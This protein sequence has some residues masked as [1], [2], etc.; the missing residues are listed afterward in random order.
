MPTFQELY[1]TRDATGA[2]A[3]IHWTLWSTEHQCPECSNSFL[4]WDSFDRV[5]GRM[6]AFI[7]CPACNHTLKRSRLPAVRS[8][9]A[10]IAY[11]TSD[12]RR[13]EKAPD[14]A[15]VAKATKSRRSQVAHWFPDVAIDPD[16][17]MY[18]RCALHLRGIT[19]VADFYTDRN[20][21]ALALLWAAITKV[22]DVRVRRALMFAFTNTAW[23][24]TRMRRFN[25]RGGQRPLTGTLYIPQLSSEAN[26]LEVMRNKVKQL[27][28]YFGV[29]SP[30][31]AYEPS[32]LLGSATDLHGIPDDC[33]DYVFTDPP[34]GSN[35]Y[36]ADCNLIWESWLGRLTD[37]TKEAVINRARNA[38][39]GGRSLGEYG[40]LM[41]AA[42]AECFRVLKPGAW[43]TVVF[44]NTNAAVW[45]VIRDSA[46][47]AG[48]LIG[49]A[50]ALDRKQQSHKG[51]KGR[52][53]GE[54][55]AHFDVVFNLQKA[56]GAPKPRGSREREV[57]L[58]ALVIEALS[59]PGIAGGGVQAVHSEVMRRL[60]S[61]GSA[62]FVEY[63][64]VRDIC[65][66]RATDQKRSPETG[67]LRERS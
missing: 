6:G 7:T 27:Q 33:V 26:V 44:H 54:A 30:A 46:C 38:S 3:L 25:A 66:R 4:L 11:A 58:E 13:F 48:F 40:S 14:D 16:R 32:I 19:S 49:E 29:F 52:S 20:L 24:G 31:P 2:P 12:G 39:R 15:D 64:D 59:D 10:W 36:Y 67:V 8:R 34:F 22:R 56:R 62:E 60:V 1:G 45:S 43:A 35:I 41:K 53:G 65:R 21:E 17:E 5:S 55:V 42:L 57:D 23:H 51:Y 63:T 50:A 61:L 9:P 28:R 37:P 18:L 47:A